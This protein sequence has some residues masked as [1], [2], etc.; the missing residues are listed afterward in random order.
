MKKIEIK[1]KIK[2]LKS[3]DYRHYINF[4]ITLSFLALGV[5]IFPNSILRVA[6]TVRNLGISFA[7]YF[8]ELWLDSNPIYPTVMDLPKWEFVPSRFEQLKIL[9]YTWDEFLEVWDRYWEVFFKSETFSEYLYV[10]GDVL[11]YGS[12]ILTILLP[13][14]LILKMVIDK[15]LNEQNNDYDEESEA[16]QRAK[17]I[18]D[19]T[20]IPVK[21]WIK[22]YIC[23]CKENDYW[24]KLWLWLWS[25]YFNIIA[26]VIEFI[27]FYLY[28]VVTFDTLGIYRQAYKLTID[29]APAVRFIPGFIWTVIIV[30][31]LELLARSIVSL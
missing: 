2:C 17:R 24:H 19:K 25:L 15:Y 23:F 27:A 21:G 5:F 16:L 30:L 7:F 20:Y 1:E 29:L 9:P 22:E 6:E 10:V 8:C 14:L 11:Y 4:V 31:A 18:A 28:F 12:Q 3:L 13:V 26:I